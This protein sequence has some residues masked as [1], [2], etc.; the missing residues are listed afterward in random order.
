[1]LVEQINY[2]G[3]P[4]CYR[5]SNGVVEL[6]VTTDVGPRIIRFGFVGEENEFVE[7]AQMMGQIGGDEWRLYGGHRFWHAPED[8]SRTY[9]PDNDP[10]TI[11]QH[12]SLV[13]LIQPTEPTTGIQKEI[14]IRLAPQE[15]RVQVTHRLRNHNLWPVE[16]APWALSVM[17]PGGTAV[18]PLPPRR[19]HEQSLLPAN[20]LTLWAYTDMS[21]PRWRW[22]RQFVMLRQDPNATTPQK[23]GVMCLDG[24]AAYARNGHLF[25]KEFEYV[26]GATYPDWGCSVELFTN[27]E[28][29]EVETL[30]PLASLAPS[31][32][33]EHIERWHLLRDVPQPNDEADIKQDIVPKVECL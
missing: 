15:A 19:S 18:V 13:R 10:V 4:N 1:M 3:W 31:A 14:D 12:R 24:W 21:D 28:M 7:L 25:V 20:T 17:A 5:L 16:L 8:L 26:T 27:H 30:A 11:E 29:L 23:V 9:A 32:T 22:G 33:V 6:V 2:Q